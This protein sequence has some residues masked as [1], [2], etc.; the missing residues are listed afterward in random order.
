MFAMM[1]H[2][3]SSSSA[4]TQRAA[5]ANANISQRLKIAGELKNVNASLKIRAPNS[6]RSIVI[7]GD[8]N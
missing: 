2:G 7:S 4:S 1:Q 5:A 8:H 3:P 6:V